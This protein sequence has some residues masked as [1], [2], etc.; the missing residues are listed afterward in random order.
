MLNRRILRIKA[1][2]TVY[3]SVLSGNMSVENANSELRES[4]EAT[5]DLFI[6]MSGI[7]APLT[8]IARDRVEALRTKFNPTE[9]ERNPNMKFCDNRLATALS[10]DL[11]L[12]KALKQKKFSWAQYDLF[13]K[14]VLDS[15]YSKQYFADYMS[16]E[17]S[18]LEEDCKLFI[19]IFEEEF[20]DS[21]ELASILEEMSLYWNDDLAY[22]LTYCCKAFED[23]AKGGS[24]AL[25]KLF[26]SQ[27]KQGIAGVED[28]EAFVKRLLGLSLVNYDKYSQMVYDSARGWDSDRLFLSDVVLVVMGITEVMDFPTIPLK[29]SINEYVELAKFYGTPKSRVFVNG[30]LDKIVKKLSEDGALKKSI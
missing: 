20:V 16:S 8:T 28:D 3:A 17:E 4:C 7:V 12:N 9:E 22:S 1:F 5:R 21:P 10:E 15:V 23:I 29:V 2:K 27:T 18:S 25:P 6:F 13:L 24:W 14:K 30:V 19:R 26:L 11:S